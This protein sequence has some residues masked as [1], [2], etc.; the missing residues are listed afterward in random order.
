MSFAAPLW[1]ALLSLMPL[2]IWFHVRR[3]EPLEVPS[4]RLW[5]LVGEGEQPQAA[6]RPPPLSLALALQLLGVLA[7]SLALAEPRLGWSERGPTVLVV[8][9]SILMTVDTGTGTSRHDEATALLADT[10]RRREA[11]WSLW[12][13]TEQAEPVLLE[14]TALHDVRH[15]LTEMRPSHLPAAWDTAAKQIVATLPPGGGHVVVVAAEPDRASAAFDSLEAS[16]SWTLEI[17]D[18]G[19]PFTSWTVSDVRVE[20]DRARSGRWLV[21][22]L[23]RRYG[24]DDGRAPEEVVVSFLPDI[25]DEPIVLERVH[26]AYSLAGTARVRTTIDATRAGILSLSVDVA[27]DLAADDRVSLRIDPSPTPVNVAVVG[28][29]GP[30]TSRVERAVE[31]LGYSR[32]APT[33]ADVVIVSGGPGPD[34]SPYKSLIWLGTAEGVDDPHALQRV[35]PGVANWQPQHPVAT[36]TAWDRV[37]AAAARDLPI[38]SDAETVVEGVASVLVATRTTPSRREVWSGFTPSDATWHE[39]SGFVTFLGDALAW[40]ATTQRTTEWCTAGASCAVP[41]VVATNAGDVRLDAHVVARWQTQH[42]TL[43]ADVTIAWVPERAGDAE[44]SAGDV[45]GRLAVQLPAASRAALARGAEAA[46]ARTAPAPPRWPDIRVWLV[47]AGLIVVLEA[48]IAGRGR[49]GF[50]RVEHWRGPSL[51]ARRRRSTAA[52]HVAVALLLVAALLTTPWPVTWTTPRLIVVGPV[53]DGVPWPADRVRSVRGDQASGIVDLEQALATVRAL[54]GNDATSV[55]WASPAPPTRGSAARALVQPMANDLRIDALPPASRPAGDIAVERVTL[56]R[57]PFAGDVVTLSAVLRSP[58]ATTTRLN[59]LRDDLSLIAVDVDLA[60]GANLVSLP[61]P[62]PDAGLVRWRVEVDA[63][64]DPFPGNDANE[65]LTDVRH[66]PRVWVMTTE[67][68]RGESLADAL[69]LQGFTVTVRPAFAMPTSLSGFEAVDAIVL[70]NVPA[71]ELTSLQQDTL[72]SWVRERGGGLVIAGGERSFGPGGY[73]ETPLDLVSPLSARV[74]RDAPEVAMVFVLDRSGSMQQFVGSVTRLDIA[75]EA[76]L[77]AT[78]LLGAQSQLAIVVFDEEARLLLPWTSSDDI[79][80]IETVLAP[81]VPGGGTAIAPGLEIARELVEQSDAASMHV[82]LMTDG[83]SQPGDMVDITQMIR[84]ADA[85][86]SAVAIGVGADVDTIREIAR[87][88][89]GAAHVTSD[90][91][92]LPGILAQEALLLSGDPVVREV[93]S[94]LRVDLDHPAMAGLPAVFPPLTA[95]VETTPKL[96]ADVLLSDAQERPILAT[97]RYGAGTVVA[98]TAQA[99]G[100]WVDGWTSV[101]AFARWW[102]QWTRWTVQPTHATGLALRATVVG[103]ALYV[104]VDARDEQGRPR[105]GLDLEAGWQPASGD[106]TE[107]RLGERMGGRYTATLPIDPGSGTITIRARDTALEP[108]SSAVTHTYPAGWAGTLRDEARVLTEW[109]GGSVLTGAGA[110]TPRPGQVVFGWVPSWRPWVVLMVLA[111][112]VSLIVRYVPGWLRR[113]ARSTSSL[114]IV[115]RLRTRAEP[116]TYE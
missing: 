29:E 116:A 44:W 104:V 65:L 108:V 16:S 91:R 62:T 81:L 97:W 11:P 15:A 70:T 74:P 3:R 86:V 83:L 21:E 35:D 75:K 1:L 7:L 98:F 4:T 34:P 80:A 31:A 38:P 92:A 93:V 9:A 22:G 102:G 72:E 24:T 100:P 48:A 14:R 50:W 41:R 90:F 87:V 103:D 20:P 2:I 63:V 19:G 64:G 67:P 107:R 33:A 42:S 73:I 8:D 5:H 106:G 6:L 94:P 53:P 84:A 68:D 46:F 13:V 23:V 79:E 26:L 27:D 76:T 51:L 12:R 95:F 60:S 55:V 77:R 49:E 111:W 52:W 58:T 59:V 88:G 71:L 25:A 17:R 114:G 32:A 69:R 18:A 28:A 78:E 10:L 89:G 54:A 30:G 36:S 99:I 105:P 110:L 45:A 112:L 66:P 40:L 96:D 37:D 43:P 101:D 61:V 47:L 82:V 115:A 39:S 85:T 113:R 109:T 57:E 56:D